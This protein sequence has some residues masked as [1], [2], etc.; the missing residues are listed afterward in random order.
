M[1]K[2]VDGFVLTVPKKNLEGYKIMATKASVVWKDHGALEYRECVGEDMTPEGV[3]P[4][5][6]LTNLKEDEVVVFAYIV[7][8]S[9][10]HRDEVNAKVMA[11]PRIKESCDPEK[12]P[13]DCSKMAYGGFQT[14]V[15]S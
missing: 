14:I 8:N 7:Y 12:M 9:R 13:F 6:T 15:E 1:S 3:L 2:Y 10:E 5:P 11:D 4:F